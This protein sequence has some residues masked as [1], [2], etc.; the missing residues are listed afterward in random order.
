[1][2]VFEDSLQQKTLE[3]IHHTPQG[4]GHYQIQGSDAGVS[5]PVAQCCGTSILEKDFLISRKDLA[6]PVGKGEELGGEGSLPDCKGIAENSRP[7]STS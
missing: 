3:K 7:S 5:D 4:N 1:M 6:S 2:C